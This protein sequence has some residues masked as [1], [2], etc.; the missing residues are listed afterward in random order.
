LQPV[1]IPSGRD[2][3]WIRSSWK[4]EELERRDWGGLARTG[5]AAAPQL[6]KVSE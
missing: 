2:D 4:K 6:L 5:Q 1:T 3:E